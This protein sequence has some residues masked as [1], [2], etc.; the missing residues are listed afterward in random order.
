VRKEHIV[1]FVL[2]RSLQVTI[3]LPSFATWVP[4]GM[5]VLDKNEGVLE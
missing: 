4:G 3:L 2:G 1:K 5:R